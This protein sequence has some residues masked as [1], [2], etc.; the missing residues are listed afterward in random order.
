L[1][2]NDKG[3]L[4]SRFANR[5]WNNCVNWTIVLLLFV[6]SLLL[7]AQVALPGWFPSA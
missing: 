1:L 4:G 2:L 6:L 5:H 3:V 7:A